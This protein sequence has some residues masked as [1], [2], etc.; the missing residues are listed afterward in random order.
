[1]PG[2]NNAGIGHQQNIFGRNFARN[3]AGT[4]R[5]VDSENDAGTRLLIERAKQ[6]V[7][8]WH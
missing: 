5:T 6:F 1:V 7:H 8:V 2:R 3:L 4:F